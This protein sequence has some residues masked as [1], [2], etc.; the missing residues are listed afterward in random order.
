ME[1]H[2][3]AFIAFIEIFSN[4]RYDENYVPRNYQTIGGMWTVDTWQKN[5]ITIQL[6]DEGYTKAILTDNLQ[7]RLNYDNSLSFSKGSVEDLLILHDNF[8]NT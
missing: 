5:G 4:I 3:Q 8:F 7:V 1:V 2:Q 6:E